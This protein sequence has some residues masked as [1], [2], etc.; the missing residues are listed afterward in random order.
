MEIKSSSGDSHLGGED[1]NKRIVEYCIE[2]FKKTHD[3]DLST[4]QKAMIRLRE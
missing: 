4:N 1:F 2:K 3:I